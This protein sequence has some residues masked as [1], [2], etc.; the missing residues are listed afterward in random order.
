M[1]FVQQVL[2]KALLPTHNSL[3]TQGSRDQFLALL[4][5]FNTA[6]KIKQQQDEKGEGGG[7]AQIKEGK[8][9]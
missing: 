8:S 4:P 3:S 2:P 6:T 9:S 5:Q 1:V 7:R